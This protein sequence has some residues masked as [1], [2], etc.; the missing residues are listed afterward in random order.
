[1][2]ALDTNQYNAN[3][4]DLSIPIFNQQ[5]AKESADKLQEELFKK[6][7]ISN[8]AE[9]FTIQ[10]AEKGLKGSERGLGGVW[11]MLGDVMKNSK[12]ASQF[13]EIG[14]ALP[15]D[16]IRAGVRGL[17]DGG[18]GGGVRATFESLA[19]GN[20]PVPSAVSTLVEKAKGLGV[21]G[22]MFDDPRAAL[23]DVVDVARRR[24]T[25]IVQKKAADLEAR[26][27]Q[28]AA[29]VEARGR[30]A[31]ARGQQAAADVEARGR[32]IAAD[33][34][35]R[36][37]DAVARGQEAAANL[38]ARGREA[39]ANVE[40][41][42]R[43]ALA[44]GQEAA[45]DVEA[46]GRGIAADVQDSM[47]HEL[48]G[49]EEPN[50]KDRAT[51]LRV[52]ARID[53]AKQQA[54]AQPEAE[55][56]P[57]PEP[58][59]VAQPEPEA[60]AEAVPVP[61]PEPEPEAL[62]EA[63]ELISPDTS[64]PLRLRANEPIKPLTAPQKLREAARQ[65]AKAKAPVQQTEVDGLRDNLTDSYD[66][67]AYD[68]LALQYTQTP[69][70]RTANF[71]SLRAQMRA[72]MNALPD[73]ENVIEQVRDASS[74][75]YGSAT[76][77]VEK[78]PSNPA[79]LSKRPSRLNDIANEESWSSGELSAAKQQEST[80]L[81]AARS[82]ASDS[83]I[84][85]LLPN[86]TGTDASGVMNNEAAIDGHNEAISQLTY[87]QPPP[88]LPQRRGNLE[89][90]SAD[91]D[92]GKSEISAARRQNRKVLQAGKNGATNEEL[93]KL[94]PVKPT[95]NN[96]QDI[97]DHDARMSAHDDA[98]SRLQVEKPIDLIAPD[99]QEPLALRPASAIQRLSRPGTIPVLPEPQP[100]APELV[101]PVETAQPNFT[102]TESPAV[103]A[104]RDAVA[105][106]YAPPSERVP[107]ASSSAFADQRIGV[108]A[109]IDKL[110]EGPL[111]QSSFGQE[112]RE[113]FVQQEVARRRGQSILKPAGEQRRIGGIDERVAEAQRRLSQ[114]RESTF[115]IRQFGVI[116]EPDDV[117]PPP[118][119]PG[120]RDYERGLSEAFDMGA[121]DTDAY[122][123]STRA[124]RLKGERD[125]R[126]SMWRKQG[127][128]KPV[129]PAEVEIA[130]AEVDV[131]PVDVQPVAQVQQPRPVQEEE[132][133]LPSG[134][135]PDAPDIV[136]DKPAGPTL[137][138]ANDQLLT[139][140]AARE[141]DRV[142][143]ERGTG[144]GGIAS[145]LE[146][147]VEAAT[148]EALIDPEIDAIPVIGDV[149]M[150]A[151]GIGG[152]LYTSF[153]NNP[154]ASPEQHIRNVMS[155]ATQLGS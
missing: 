86:Y 18:L 106:M 68:K 102:F 145:D 82:G 99:T 81:N 28:A 133:E 104:Y 87:E 131:A 132:E 44:R 33:V 78:A 7:E 12:A 36:G 54:I 56:V 147:G 85:E 103:Q 38:E 112:G 41:Q 59:A 124:A 52:Q 144:I 27:R 111:T 63:T 116:R 48:F 109:P 90:I 35:A 83:E 26:G 137:E 127:Q 6:L 55:A 65:S 11:R 13:N 73:P 119:P 72:E 148:A 2:S 50:A 60:E 91:E 138:K 70:D 154:K 149:A 45:A 151:A 141:S 139:N 84:N 108:E 34:E 125:A 142:I 32:G 94:R 20:V 19:N 114:P 79:R 61:E 80:V 42:G 57:E 4:V 47:M 110:D 21:D 76:A 150:L 15:L 105:K 107:G 135:Q 25:G 97:L 62:P 37:R 89:K 9:P 8:F 126:E 74:T 130:P 129:A 120:A 117:A 29:D 136:L 152:A 75:S 143:A 121:E 10:M 30:D 93:E 153:A 23:D 115:D 128:Q 69:I 95:S 14:R 134:K 16:T 140:V 92:W 53:A 96:A 101:A 64:E 31:V 66:G 51:A 123:V 67:N 98:V 40:A 77:R 88:R 39:A 71:S 155:S 122:G 58:E 1:M 113:G 46:R 146:G 43:D 5:K 24:A 17:Q 100:P 3:Q 49:D 118:P 22:S